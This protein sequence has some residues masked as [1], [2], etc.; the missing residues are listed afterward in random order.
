MSLLASS[1][2]LSEI[3]KKK[4]LLLCAATGDS[5]EGLYKELVNK[6]KA[7]R[8]LFEDLRIIKLDEWGGVPENHPSTCEYYIRRA[9]LGPM[10]I[11]SENY[12][13][14][15]SD[16]ADP[17][18]E[19]KR[20]QS[21]LDKNGPID[22]CILG[23]GKNGHLGLNEPGPFLEPH[24]HVAPLSKES[25]QHSMLFSTE[26]KPRFGL[27]L[28]I[29]DIISA[30]QIIILIG[31]ENKEEILAELLQEKVS[32]TL[33]ASFLWL[34]PNVECIIDQTHFA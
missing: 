30:R 4:N 5:P 22:I 25:L 13:S 7:D 33:P 10:E 34:H 26:I 16:P 3:E 32:T 29:R 19:C 31:G 2:V 18:L 28:G 1:I 20:I 15:A 27:T 9:L 12:I 24:C 8:D 23:L 6:S 21:E 14:F 17:V 11:P